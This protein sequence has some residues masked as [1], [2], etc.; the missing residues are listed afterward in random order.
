MTFGVRNREYWMAL[1]YMLSYQLLAKLGRVLMS[2]ANLI[3]SSVLLPSVDPR[4]A[5]VVDKT[6]PPDPNE[7]VTLFLVRWELNIPGC[8]IECNK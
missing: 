4:D 6:L 1:S 8:I 3:Y 5:P 2:S 7:V